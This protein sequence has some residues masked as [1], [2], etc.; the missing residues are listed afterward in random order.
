MSVKNTEKNVHFQ[1]TGA[2]TFREMVYILGVYIN[3]FPFISWTKF[4]IVPSEAMVFVV[5]RQLVI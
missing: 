1:I 3:I 5:M 2:T 4:A